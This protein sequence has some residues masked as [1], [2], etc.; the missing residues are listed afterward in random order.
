MEK[1]MYVCMYVCMTVTDSLLPLEDDEYEYDDIL[2]RPGVFDVSGN[3][4]IH[5]NFSNG[6]LNNSLDSPYINN[7]LIFNTHIFCHTLLKSLMKKKRGGT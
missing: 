7:N 1:D 6:T 2:L 4:S 3:P 5:P